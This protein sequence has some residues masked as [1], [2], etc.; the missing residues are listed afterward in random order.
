MSKGKLQVANFD[1]DTTVGELKEL[2]EEHGKVKQVEIKDGG[3][4][5]FVDMFKKSEAKKAQEALDGS[6]FKG[7]PLK[8]EE[9]RSFKGGGRRRRGRR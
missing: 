1:L 5:G 7:Q 8:V 4:L 6:D 9:A 3:G 2:F